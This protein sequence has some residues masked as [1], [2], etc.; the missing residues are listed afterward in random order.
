M[1]C[2]AAVARVYDGLFT[3]IE[4]HVFMIYWWHTKLHYTCYTGVTIKKFPFFSII[5]I[6][7]S[8]QDLL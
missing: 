3:V 1:F 8:F 2:A 5:V 4:I 7:Y 6:K